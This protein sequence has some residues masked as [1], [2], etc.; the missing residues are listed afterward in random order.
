MLLPAAV[1]SGAHSASKHALHNLTD[2]M[3]LELNPLGIDV[4]L[5][6]PGETGSLHCRAEQ[7]SYY[8]DYHHFAQGLQ[9]VG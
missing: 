9:A 3:R 6:A 1:A 8:N 7:G 4:M 5:V 2:I